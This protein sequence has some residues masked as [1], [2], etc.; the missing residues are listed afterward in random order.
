M[1]LHCSY[2]RIY[3]SQPNLTGSLLMQLKRT[4]SYYRGLTILSKLLANRELSDI[5]L[6]ELFLIPDN[7]QLYENVEAVLSVIKMAALLIS[8][9]S[10][11]K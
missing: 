9:K 5:E 7:E 1:L 10:V 2:C 6:L 8:M 11:V 4:L 3:N